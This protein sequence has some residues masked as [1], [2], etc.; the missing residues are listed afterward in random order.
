MTGESFFRSVHRSFLSHQIDPIHP[1]TAANPLTA[2]SPAASPVP[3]PLPGASLTTRTSPQAAAAVVGKL[4]PLA[5]SVLQ[6]VGAGPVTYC[7]A[8]VVVVTVYAGPIN[9]VAVVPDSIALQISNPLQTISMNQDN[10]GRYRGSLL[11]RPPSSSSSTRH[12]H[13]RIRHHR[14]TITNRIIR[15]T[16]D[17]VFWTSISAVGVCAT[18]VVWPADALT[19]YVCVLGAYSCAVLEE[20]GGGPAVV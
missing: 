1:N 3:T 8:V 6:I 2:A 18:A 11:T 15:T 7:V 17:M 5:N 14:L 12:P 16:A 19:V 13:S 10:K 9:P 4:S 20:D